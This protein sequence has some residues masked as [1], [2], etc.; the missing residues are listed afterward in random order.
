[1]TWTW[2]YSLFRLGSSAE[3]PRQGTHRQR[4]VRIRSRAHT[5]FGVE[6]CAQNGYRIA[7]VNV[8]SGIVESYAIA[9]FH[10]AEEAAAALSTINYRIGADT[11]LTLPRREVL[12]KRVRLPATDKRQ[13]KQMI[14]HEARALAPWPE[15]ETAFSYRLNSV[16]DDGYSSVLIVLVHRDTIESH[17]A[18]LGNAGIVPTRVE[19]TTLSLGRLLQNTELDERPAVARINETCFEFSRYC[20]GNP[21]FSR[22]ISPSA[23]FGE[24]VADSLSVDQRKHGPDSSCTLL[25]VSDAAEVNVKTISQLHGSRKVLPFTEYH[26]SLLNGVDPLSSDDVACI[27]A[28]LSAETGLPTEDL[29]PREERRRLV[30]RGALVEGLQALGLAIL[31]AVLVYGIVMY[32]IQQETSYAA[33]AHTRI[34]VLRSEMGDLDVRSAQVKL[35]KNELSTISLPLE[36]VLAL[37]DRVPNSV[38]ISHFHYDS[39]G[40]LLL[41]GEASDFADVRELLSALNDSPFFS[42]VTLSHT[43][44]SQQDRSSIVEFRLTLDV[45]KDAAQ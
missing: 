7:R 27:G 36:I 4:A 1:M 10:A 26:P 23:D 34:E 22:G 40:G 18:R 12:L 5:S 6:P 13:I 28:A 15:N 37:Y 24:L 16:D 32:L 41:A 14:P 42:D 35:L 21:V 30:L 17:L 38:A 25:L 3:R 8:R 29:L 9:E 31:A 44:R 2:A 39:R 43:S 20:D 45:R 19:V 11:V 33:R